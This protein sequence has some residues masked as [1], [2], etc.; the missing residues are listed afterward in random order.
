MLLLPRRSG[1][2]AD[3]GAHAE[4]LASGSARRSGAECIARTRIRGPLRPGEAKLMVARQGS[5]ARRGGDQWDNLCKRGAARSRS[6]EFFER[7]GVQR[8][9]RTVANIWLG[10]RNSVH[11]KQKAFGDV[12]RIYIDESPLGAMTFGLEEPP[13]KSRSM[14]TVLALDALLTRPSKNFTGRNS[15]MDARGAAQGLERLSPGRKSRGAGEDDPFRLPADG[16]YRPE[17]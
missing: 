4:H 3:C 16:R 11:E 2:R 13:T 9:A 5:G 10:A 7:C 8:Q 12:G 6:G 17:R 1:R 15:L 14:R